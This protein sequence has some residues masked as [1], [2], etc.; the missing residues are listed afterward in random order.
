[1]ENNTNSDYQILRELEQHINTLLEKHKK[2]HHEN[3]L[4]KQQQQTLL[5]EK[6]DLLE[7][8]RQVQDKIEAMVNQL[9]VLEKST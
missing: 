7:K 1:M 5:N 9:R 8:N 2:L 6:A 4:L 3:D